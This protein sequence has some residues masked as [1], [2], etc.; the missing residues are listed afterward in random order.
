MGGS[1]LIP[2][3]GGVGDPKGKGG[4]DLGKGYY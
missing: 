2:E 4:I 1:I 3:S